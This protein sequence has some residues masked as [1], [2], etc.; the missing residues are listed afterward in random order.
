MGRIKEELLKREYKAMDKLSN[1]NL[2]EYYLSIDC[3]YKPQAYEQDNYYL[4]KYTILDLISLEPIIISEKVLQSEL[5]KKIPKQLIKMIKEDNQTITSNFNYMALINNGWL[6][7]N[8]LFEAIP[9]TDNIS[10]LNDLIIIPSSEKAI[11]YYLFE[12]ANNT[13][14]IAQELYEHRVSTNDNL[15]QLNKGLDLQ[16]YLTQH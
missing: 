4:L 6:S 5:D 14:S 13:D 16:N 1:N 3:E 7:E 9:K 10:S 8:Y 12:I 11:K 15:N 2:R